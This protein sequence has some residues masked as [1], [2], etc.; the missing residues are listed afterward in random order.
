MLNFYTKAGSVLLIH[1]LF[2]VH[3]HCLNATFY[4]FTAMGFSALLFTDKSFYFWGK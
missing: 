1:L 2:L 3:F 4:A